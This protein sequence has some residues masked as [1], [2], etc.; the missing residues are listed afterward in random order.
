VARDSIVGARCCDEFAPPW[1]SPLGDD[2]IPTHEEER[3]MKFM[4]FT[5]RDSSVM[6]DPAQ[7]AAIPAAVDAW[8]TEMDGRGVRLQGHVL[9]PIEET[10]AIRVRDGEVR[11]DDRPVSDGTVQIADFN[12]LE[13]ADLDEALEVAAKNPGARFGTLELRPILES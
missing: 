2:G 7:R 13:C 12:I 11:L 10:K 1:P 5:Y 9:G 6:L 4:L 3:A 8:C